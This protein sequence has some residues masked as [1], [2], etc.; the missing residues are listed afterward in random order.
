M[1]KVLVTGSAG[2]IGSHLCDKLT[3]RYKV[4]GIDNLSLGKKENISHLKDNF[5]FHQCEILDPKE[6]EN[7]FRIHSFDAIFHLAA[8]SDISKGDPK[9]D[10]Q[11]TLSTT[12]VLLEKCRQKGIKQFIFASSSAIYGETARSIDEDY[13]PLLPVG[14]YGAAKLASEAFISSYSAMYDI[15]AWICRFPNVVGERMTH[16]VIYDLKNKLKVSPK[17]LTVYGDGTQSKPYIYVK[18]LVDAILFIW[19][20]SKD[21]LN[22][23][24]ISGIGETTVKEIVGLIAGDAEIIYSGGERGW[25]GDVPKYRFNTMKLKKLGWTLKRNSLDA[26]K[27]SI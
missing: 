25:K 20:K 21:R 8:N 6:I 27:L 2:F 19:K 18:D 7:I 10:F 5:T 13:G 16:G 15:Q 17:T 22:V 4:I 9:T 23:Y 3:K 26:I 1:K 11:N 14:H 12:L 24:N